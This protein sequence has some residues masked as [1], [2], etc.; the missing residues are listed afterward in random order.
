MP[1]FFD[2]DP[3]TGITEYFDYDEETGT[4]HITHSQD[5]Q[6]ALDYAKSL[7]DTGI[8]DK[9]IKAGL[10]KYAILPAN[11]QIELRSKGLDIYSQEPAMMNK[12]FAEIDAN[13]PHFKT[14]TKKH[15]VKAVRHT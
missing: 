6:A 12:V 1:Q 4:A 9:G 8:A 3:H 15:R 2:Y 14:T 11:V 13:Y 5:V 7:R 10:W